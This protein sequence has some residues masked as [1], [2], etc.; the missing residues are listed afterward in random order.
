M[1][2]RFLIFLIGLIFSFFGAVF[3]VIKFFKKIKPEDD[4]FCEKGV[5]SNSKKE[6]EKNVNY[7]EDYWGKYF[8]EE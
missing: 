8:V 6:K 1:N 3:I 5:D 4:E 2:K 7:D